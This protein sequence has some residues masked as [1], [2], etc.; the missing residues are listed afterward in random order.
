MNGNNYVKQLND[1]MGTIFILISTNCPLLKFTGELK[2]DLM[3]KLSDIFNHNQHNY[4][5][6]YNQIFIYIHVSNLKQSCKFNRL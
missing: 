3:T 1:F 4:D 6:S 2:S 5:H